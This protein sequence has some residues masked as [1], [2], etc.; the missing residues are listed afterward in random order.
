MPD[1]MTRQDA[2]RIHQRLDEFGV[3]QTQ[4]QIAVARIEQKIELAPKVPARP[5]PDFLAHKAEHENAAKEKRSVLAWVLQTILAP[6]LAAIGGAI[7][8]VMHWGKP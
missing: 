3:V 2:D 7:I 1:Y 5:C 6:A 4:V 8:A